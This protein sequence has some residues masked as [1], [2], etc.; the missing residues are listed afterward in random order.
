MAAM[1]RVGYG[2]LL[3]LLG[4]LYGLVGTGSQQSTFSIG[5]AVIPWG[6][7]VALLGVALLLG[8]IRVIVEHGP[9]RVYALVTAIG[10][11]LPIV[12]F[13]QQSAGG[14]VLIPAN[15]AGEAW[16]FGPVLIAVVAIAWPSF[17]LGRSDPSGVAADA[18]VEA[19]QPRTLP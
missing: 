4:L 15:A 1:T 12:L 6:I 14:S 2:I 7:V 3:F 10:I 16:V 19:E 13:S 9:G 17:L 5:A 11:F 8:G 18:P